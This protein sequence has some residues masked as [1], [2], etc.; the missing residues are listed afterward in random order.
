MRLLCLSNGHGEDQIGARIL[1]ALQKL[2]PEIETTALPIVGLGTAYQNLGIAIAGPVEV[3]P[4]G[5]FIYQD[6]RQ[7]WRDLRAGLLGLLGKQVQAIQAWQQTNQSLPSPHLILAVGDIVPLGL[8][9]LSRNDYAFV[10]TA[11][12]EYYL[13]DENG[14]FFSQGW[15]RGWAGSDYLPWEQWLMR[16]RRCLGVFPRDSLTHKVLRGLGIRSFNCGNPMM[17]ELVP[18]AQPR[19]TYP[20]AL[21]ITLLPGSRPP[22]ADQNW[23]QILAAIDHFSDYE[24]S[25]LFWGAISPGLELGEILNPL[26]RFGWEEIAR[27]AWLKIGDSAALT[28]QKSEGHLVL[29]QQAYSDCLHLGD[30]AIAQAGT[31]TEQFVG[32]GKP[33]ITFPG[34]G[35]QFTPLFARRQARLLGI[36]VHLVENPTAV[37]PKIIELRNDHP[38]LDLI[39]QNG[40][41]RMGHPGAAQNIANTIYQLLNPN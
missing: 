1:E 24:P 16:Q 23:G 35:P 17:D 20:Q 31:A 19:T 41:Q 8:A 2:A 13:R 18:P 6:G 22:E 12:S 28:F 25:C 10:G 29:T 14:T 3:M 15:G 36:S 27:P 39:R 9:G 40:Q 5:G 32:L 38:R 4:S 11:K 34:Q 7:L 33:V 37:M 30:F 21:T 26:A